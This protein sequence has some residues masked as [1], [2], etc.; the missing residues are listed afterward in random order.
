MIRRKVLEKVATF[1]TW[2]KLSCLYSAEPTEK[3]D[4]DQSAVTSS[5]VESSGDGMV[6]A[7]S[8]EGEEDMVDVTMQDAVQ[9]NDA[10]Q[11]EP[12]R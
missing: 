12:E 10:S 9:T 3:L 7:S 8:V 6:T 1:T 4:Q 2:P 5:D 11:Q